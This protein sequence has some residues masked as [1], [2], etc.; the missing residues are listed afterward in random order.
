MCRR[1][2]PFA[3]HPDPTMPRLRFRACGRV[4]CQ[5]GTREREDYQQG[6][7]TVLEFTRAVPV[8]LRGG[9]GLDAESG[10]GGDHRRLAGVDGGDDLGVVDPLQI[11]GGDP[12][13]GVPQLALDDVEAGRPRGRVRRRGRGAAGGA[14]VAAARR[15]SRRRAVVGRGLSRWPRAGRGWGRR[16]RTAAGRP[17]ASRGAR[18]RAG[19]GPSPTGPCRPRGGGRPCRGGRAPIRRGDRG[20]AR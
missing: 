8:R 4:D 16:L 13:V 3:Q 5:A 10:A 17:A 12:E 15:R 6:S 9:A 20:R 2:R 11:D 19:G 14:R 7:S 18:A 1:G